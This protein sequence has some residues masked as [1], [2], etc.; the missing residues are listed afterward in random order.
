MPLEEG[1]PGNT[2]TPVLPFAQEPELLHYRLCHQTCRETIAAIIAVGS[3]AGAIV[4]F[5]LASGASITSDALFLAVCGG[6][7]LLIGGSIICLIRMFPVALRITS[8]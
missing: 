6:A 4:L 7:V 8:M 1:G 2:S 5:V 3:F